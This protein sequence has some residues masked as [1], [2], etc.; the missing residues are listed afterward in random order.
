MSRRVLRVAVAH[1]L[2]VC[3]AFL[4]LLSVTPWRMSPVAA[5]PEWRL[6]WADEFNKDGAPD[7]ANWTYEHGFVRNDEAQWYQPQNAS[8]REGLLII[9]ARRERVR[10]DGFVPGSTK[11]PARQEFAEYTSSSL[12]TKGLH[13]WRYGRFEL[14]ARI[15]TRS[16]MWPA[17]W[18]LGVDGEWPAGGEI[19]MLEYYRGMLLANVAWGS[20]QRWVATWDAVR[21]PVTSLGTGWADGFHVWRMD[22]D[23]HAI[24]LYM[25]DRLLNET[26]V[27]DT[28]DASRHRDPFNAAHYMLLNLAIGGTNGGDPS[29]TAFPAKFEIDYVRVYEKE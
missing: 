20:D 18:T 9:E 28:I 27:A 26:T 19:D 23:A 11:W 10:N 25:D 5:E 16:G 22:W 3:A 8:C 29:V 6:V 2:R 4:S 12:I 17:W 24:R 15:D 14:R 13:Q 21:T 1:G 7:P